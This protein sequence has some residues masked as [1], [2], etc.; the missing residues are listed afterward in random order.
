MKRNEANEPGVDV[1][2]LK[3]IDKKLNNLLDFDDFDKTFKPKEQK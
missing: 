2:N 3:G 1:F